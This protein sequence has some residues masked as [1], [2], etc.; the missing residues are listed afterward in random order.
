MCFG[1]AFE[2]SDQTEERE[3]SVPESL[4]V[5]IGCFFQPPEGVGFQRERKRGRGKGRGG[6]CVRRFPEG[7][8]A[9]VLSWKKNK[10]ETGGSRVV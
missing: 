10:N 8:G 9:M 3:I 2:I 7:G 5:L 1:G 4:F 6:H